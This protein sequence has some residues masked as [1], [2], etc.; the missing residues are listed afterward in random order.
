MAV[1]LQPNE[2][3]IDK[4]Q[5]QNLLDQSDELEKELETK[6]CEIK[7]LYDCAIKIFELVGLAKNGVVEKK[8]FQPGGF[9]FKPLVGGMTDISSLLLK[10]GFSKKAE[11][12][13]TEK[14]KFFKEL[15]PVFEK[16]AAEFAV[17]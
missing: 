11:A 15:I 7:Q 2:T 12:Q 17:Q 3:V 4:S 16:Y 14:F 9:S 5:L 1:D 6:R 13:L 8:Y 10:A